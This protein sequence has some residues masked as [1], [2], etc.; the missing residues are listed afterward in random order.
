MAELAA[1]GVRRGGDAG[2]KAFSAAP[3][4]AATVVATAAASGAADVD[5]VSTSRKSY[6]SCP[7]ASRLMCSEA[8]VRREP[9]DWMDFSI[10]FSPSTPP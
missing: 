6:I 8:S 9:E 3:A 10:L 2:C 5:G 7:D 4:G 1:E